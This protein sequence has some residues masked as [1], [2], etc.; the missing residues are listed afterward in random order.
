MRYKTFFYCHSFYF[1]VGARP[2]LGLLINLQV[3]LRWVESYRMP[4]IQV[5]E[6]HGMGCVPDS[7]HRLVPVDGGGSIAFKTTLFTERPGM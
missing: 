2:R 1:Q 4:S 3:F 5:T 6:E 7:G